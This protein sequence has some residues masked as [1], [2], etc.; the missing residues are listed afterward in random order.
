[1]TSSDFQFNQPLNNNRI[2]IKKIDANNRL[3][4]SI[5]DR[6]PS[7]TVTAGI[8]ADELNQVVLSNGET[9]QLQ[10]P[11]HTHLNPGDILLDTKG[12]MVRI[13]AAMQTVLAVTHTDIQKIVYLALSAQKQGRALGWLNM[14]LLLAKDA[15]LQQFLEK[16]G[17][18]TQLIEGQL[19]SNIYLYNLPTPHHHCGD[20]VDT[21]D[22]IHTH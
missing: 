22:F 3:T 5:L 12:M 10:L 9:V 20:K 2:F 15:D 8:L 18:N 19:S 6:I 17:F 16:N 14:Q 7:F 11:H 13:D 21:A 4:A 1:M